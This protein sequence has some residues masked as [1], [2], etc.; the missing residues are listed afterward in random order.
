MNFV[1][2]Q[3]EKKINGNGNYSISLINFLN[4]TTGDLNLLKIASNYLDD[5]PLLNNGIGDTG[6]MEKAD[7]ILNSSSFSWNPSEQPGY[8]PYDLT[9]NISIDVLGKY[10]N[11]NTSAQGY[12]PIAAA[13][14]PSLKVILSSKV[15]GIP[16]IFGG[17]Y[18]TTKSKDFWED[19]VG[20]TP[21]ILKQSSGK[22][23]IF[24]VRFE[25]IALP[26]DS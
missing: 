16:M 6:D 19:N 11:V 10:N 23:F 14:K 7:V 3:T 1:Y 13:Y 5:V 26:G 24:D 9:N 12:A 15:L 4:D 21:L 22:N 17:I 2:N 20:I 18:D 25:S 8:F